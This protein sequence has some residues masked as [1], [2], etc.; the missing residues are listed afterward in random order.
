MKIA[1]N[2]RFLLKPFTGIGQYTINLAKELAKID[3]KNQYV[4]FVPE[5]V[6]GTVKEVF[7]KNVEFHVLPEKKIPGAGARKTWWEQIQL[8]EVVLKDGFEMA[9]FPYPSNPWTKDFYKSGVKTV[10]TVHDCIPWKHK[11]YHHGILSKL[12]H[13]QTKKAV[14][15]SNLI[16]T[17]S[18]NS[19]KEIT[20][21]CQT[22]PKKIQVI[23]NDAS[24]NYKTHSEEETSKRV[25]SAFGLEK[26][27]FFLYCGGYDERKN[28]ERLIAEYE[29][30]AQKSMGISLVL[31]GGKLHNDNLYSSFD[32]AK[33]TV[34]EI[35]KT[36]FLDEI[37]LKVLY[38]NCL[39]FI[40]L[41]KDE[42]FNIPLIEAANCAA[43]LIISDIAV[44]REIAKDAAIFVDPEKI[45]D[46]QQEM[47]KMLDRIEREKYSQKSLE[48]AKKYSWKISAQK[49]KDV[50][51]S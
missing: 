26:S 14:N 42:G 10:V 15:K 4:F 3:S 9:L 6:L 2:G 33:N 11:E 23:Y 46:T 47:Q 36:G 40:H 30:F 31:A 35:I 51:F 1:I 8:P 18:E 49:L 48:L 5:K 24:D 43:P 13:A 25:L 16:L 17:V 27:R 21:I 50:L 32:K 37:E 44:H 12:Y 7:P 41:S 34:G 29:L 19:K 38:K 20:H 22:D 28:V 39:A 45:G